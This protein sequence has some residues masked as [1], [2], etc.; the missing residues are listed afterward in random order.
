VAFFRRQR[1]RERLGV[2]ECEHEDFAGVDVLGDAGNQAVRAEFRLERRA[3]LDV[4]GRGA[5]GKD[6]GAH[7][8]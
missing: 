8:E 2:H 5:G 6:V 1:V 4:G 7:A 3:E